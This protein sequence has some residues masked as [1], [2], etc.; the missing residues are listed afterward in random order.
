MAWIYVLLAA[1]C[2]MAWPLGAKMSNG[3]SNWAKNWPIILGTFAVMLASFGLMA[4]ATRSLPVGTV[5][6]VWTGLGTTGIVLTGMFY[7]NEPRDLPR[8]VCL[9]LIIVGVVGLKLLEKPQP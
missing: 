3:F 2:E 8:F 4:L 7:M 1:V 5:Y 6:A 9:T